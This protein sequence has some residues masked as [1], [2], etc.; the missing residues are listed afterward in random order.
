MKTYRDHIIKGMLSWSLPMLM[1]I[2]I[3]FLN[4][5]LYFNIL[6]ISLIYPLVLINVSKSP[7]FRISTA[8]LAY[9]GIAMLILSY[10]IITW[11]KKG[12]EALSNPKEHRTT[13]A[14]IYAGYYLLFFLMIFLSGAFLENLY[15]GT[16]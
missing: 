13:A 5:K 15:P 2:L 7:A 6:M 14:F 16:A 4:D 10:I 3:S 8:A 12:K 1:P 11:S 9:A